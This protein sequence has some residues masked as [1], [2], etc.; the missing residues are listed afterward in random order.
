MFHTQEDRVIE[1]VLYFTFLIDSLLLQ[2][3]QHRG[4]I[5]VN[6]T[7]LE[8]EVKKAKNE[9][10]KSSQSQLPKVVEEVLC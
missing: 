10:S 3:A 6:W 1:I 4:Y 7:K 2:I 9:L 8:R 5:K